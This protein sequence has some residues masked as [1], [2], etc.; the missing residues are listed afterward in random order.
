MPKAQREKPQMANEC[1]FGDHHMCDLFVIDDD[2]RIIRPWITAWSDARS[3]CFVGF[4]VTDKPNSKTIAETLIRA[5]METPYSPFSGMPSMIYIDNGKDYRGRRME[6]D[7][8][9]EYSI[10]R[11]NAGLTKSSV[12]Q[13]MGIGVT[14]ALP[15]K[16]WSK[17]IERLF[18]TLENCFLRGLPGW[19]GGTPSA[20]PQDLTRAA[21]EKLAVRGKL[22]TLRQFEQKLRSEIMP[23]YHAER[24]EN[25]QSPLEIYQSSEKARPDDIASMDMLGLLRTSICER[26]V[27]TQ[28]VKLNKILYWHDSMARCIGEYVT[29]RYDEDDDSCV[30]IVA[31]GHYLCTAPQKDRLRLVGE[32]SDKLGAHMSLQKRTKADAVAGIHSAQ[33]AA[34]LLTHNTVFEDVTGAAAG[35]TTPEYRRAA[36][37]RDALEESRRQT[38]A[39]KQSGD[40]VRDM[41][42]AIGKESNREIAAAEY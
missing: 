29:V 8:E 15:Y 31:G 32:D 38:K 19:C 16:A 24:F 13:A 35:L 37:D 14:H 42:Q 39:D 41:F 40:A 7:K 12:V 4:G 10:G 22:L 9:V 28:G 3:G 34:E 33:R 2:G 5:C 1:F 27:S 36:K 18:G 21:L 17:T 23:A 25:A 26:K 20:R 30:T 11:L 6:G